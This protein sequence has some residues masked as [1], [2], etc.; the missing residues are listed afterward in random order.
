MS[1]LFSH[2]PR[3]QAM[4][5]YLNKR[6]YK[7]ERRRMLASKKMTDLDARIGKRLRAI[8][9][10]RGITIPE[11]AAMLPEPISRQAIE[12]YERG[13]ARM[14]ASRLFTLCAALDT[15][16]N[17]F[18]LPFSDAAYLDDKPEELRAE[19]LVAARWF[20]QIDDPHVRKSVTAVMRKIAQD[21]LF[22]SPSR[23]A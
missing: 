21:R 22:Y 15:T 5:L 20:A 7:R 12:K 14:P 8:R 4:P 1:R 9:T 23:L 16:P 18:W 11:L 13:I 6:N 3:G 10:G 19:T 17:E 2:K